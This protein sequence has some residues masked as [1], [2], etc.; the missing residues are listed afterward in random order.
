MRQVWCSA[1]GVGSLCGIVRGFRCREEEAWWHE[2]GVVARRGEEPAH[3]GGWRVG[4]WLCVREGAAGERGGEVRGDLGGVA[5]VAVEV[6]L[7]GQRE[8]PVLLPGLLHP[9]HVLSLVFFLGKG[10]SHSPSPSR[11]ESAATQVVTNGSRV[12]QLSTPRA[13]RWTLL[14]RSLAE[15][16]SAPITCEMRRCCTG[17]GVALG[18]NSQ[19]SVPRLGFWIGAIPRSF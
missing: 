17:V 5:V 15:V 12:G 3:P 10:T 6:G 9:T 13:A 18:C 19:A 16:L 8:P 4:G 1:C 14:E 11:W 2:G 7:R